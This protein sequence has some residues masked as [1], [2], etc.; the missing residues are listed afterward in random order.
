METL[1]AFCPECSAGSRAVPS[2]SQLCKSSEISTQPSSISY[3]CEPFKLSNDRIGYKYF[4]TIR[5]QVCIPKSEIPNRVMRC[6]LPAFSSFK[7]RA[8][9]PR[10]HL[11][12]RPEDRTG[13]RKFFSLSSLPHPWH[14]HLIEVEMKTATFTL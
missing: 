14:S 4:F 11:L 7:I 10:R 1:K 2:H 3:H 9:L 12:P 6:F 8:C 5:L 13:M